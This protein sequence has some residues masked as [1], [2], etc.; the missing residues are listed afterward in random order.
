MK[1]TLTLIVLLICMGISAQTFDFSCIDPC[2]SF[3]IEG[4]IWNGT[5][6]GDRKS[7]RL[8]VNKDDSFF[9][10]DGYYHIEFPDGTTQSGEV[11]NNLN[12]SSFYPKFGTTT[13]TVS[14]IYG[15]DSCNLSHSFTYF[16]S[17]EVSTWEDLHNWAQLAEVGDVAHLNGRELKYSYYGSTAY[18]NNGFYFDIDDDGKYDFYFLDSD[19][20]DNGIKQVKVSNYLPSGHSG[21][22]SFSV[23][24]SLVQ[25]IEMLDVN[26]E[27]SKYGRYVQGKNYASET[28]RYFK[29]YDADNYSNNPIKYYYEESYFKFKL[30]DDLIF[31]TLEEAATY[32]SFAERY[33]GFYYAED[34]DAIIEI[35]PGFLYRYRGKV[36]DGCISSTPPESTTQIITPIHEIIDGVSYSYNSCSS[37]PTPCELSVRFTYDEETDRL[38]RSYYS[39]GWHHSYYIKLE[40]TIC[41]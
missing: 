19:Y 5:L 39:N 22:H 26:K 2:D 16:V 27:A 10:N 23:K 33:E 41:D 21:T 11:D 32:V 18:S 35:G 13:I 9:D 38:R 1:K 15:D 34:F 4:Y 24:T 8:T 36:A 17:S 29:I 20:N 12:T 6:N 7:I 14:G 40:P 31:H 30:S 37:N 28:D 25:T 3:S